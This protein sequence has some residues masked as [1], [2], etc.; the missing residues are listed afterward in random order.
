VENI[1]FV[2]GIGRRL[3]MV[4]ATGE[5][6]ESLRL[7]RELSDAPSTEPALIE[8]AGRLGAFSHPSFAQVRR[9]ERLR[10]GLSG[11][12][13]VSAAVPGVRLAEVLRLAQNNGVAPDP[14]VSLCLLQ[15][16]VA[17]L[18]AFHRQSRDVA[19]G[20]LAPERVIVRPD[21][22]AVITEYVLAPAVEQLRMPRASL[23]TQFR[24]PVPAVAGSA[25][26]DQMTDVFQLGMLALGLVLGRPIRREEFPQKL[27]ELLA[28]TATAEA[29]GNRASVSRALRSWVLRTLQFE[30]RAAFRTMADAAIGLDAIVAE[31]AIHKVSPAAVVKHLAACA[32]EPAT[33]PEAAIDPPVAVR[34]AAPAPRASASLTRR[35]PRSSPDASTTMRVSRGTPAVVPSGA[36]EKPAAASSPPPSKPAP[37]GDLAAASAVPAS[38]VEPIAMPIAMPVSV[39]PRRDP[40]SFPGPDIG[41]SLARRAARV[42]VGA[43]RA[44]FRNLSRFDSTAAARGVRVG[45]VSLGLVALYGAT[46]LGARGYLALPSLISGRG[47]LVVESRPAGAELYVDGFPSGRTPATLELRAGEHTLALTTGRNTTLVPVVVVSGARRVERVEIRSRRQAPAGRSQQLPSPRLPK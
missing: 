25:R 11:L 31:E 35:F 13:V 6:V 28:E 27:Q 37:A 12:A 17:G 45:V 7:C 2:D 15:E 3:R 26:L 18:A 43:T 22:H 46:F 5:E 8:R 36:T 21:G 33:R 19:H 39:E 44:S 29:T 38:A 23:W 16:I 20:T 40:P 9:V 1:F 30:S 34:P 41:P 42:F 32:A 10:G 47:T 4:D 14:H 24:V